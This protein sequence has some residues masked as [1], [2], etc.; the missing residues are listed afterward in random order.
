MRKYA[1][2]YKEPSLTY[3]YHEKRPLSEIGGIEF[4]ERLKECILET[5]FPGFEHED[6]YYL[7]IRHHNPDRSYELNF[8][9]LCMANNRQFTPYLHRRDIKA[10]KLMGKMLYQE[11][12]KLSDPSNKRKLL[13]RAR[14][15]VKKAKSFILRCAD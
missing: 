8:Y 12:P 10:H 1:Q 14:G 9:T 3:V 11:N 13:T 4:E 2:R 15:W 6:F 5:F 7:F